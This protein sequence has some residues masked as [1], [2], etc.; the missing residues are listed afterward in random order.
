MKLLSEGKSM[1][2]V[3]KYLQLELKSL[4]WSKYDII[5]EGAVYPRCLR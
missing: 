1:I 5:I 4:Q 2:Y 3:E